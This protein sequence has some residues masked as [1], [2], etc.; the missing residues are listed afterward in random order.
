MITERGRHERARLE[1]MW[2]IDFESF[3]QVLQ[4]IKETRMINGV[5]CNSHRNQVSALTMVL[6]ELKLDSE[7]GVSSLS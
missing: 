2:K 3:P 5:Q 6:S 4:V 7:Q 1:P